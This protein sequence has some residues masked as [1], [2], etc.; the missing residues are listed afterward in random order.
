MGASCMRPLPRLP[1]TWL[2]G[3]GMGWMQHDDPT[4]PHFL[5]SC[6]TQPTP[7][8]PSLNQPNQHTHT[9][10]TFNPQI[11][12]HDQPIHYK[13]LTTGEP[14]GD[15]LLLRLPPADHLVLP[16]ADR[17]GLHHAV[18]QAPGRSPFTSLARKRA[19]RST[20]V[21]VADFHSAAPQSSTTPTPPT[22]KI[23]HA[24]NC[25]SARGAV[26]SS[27]CWKGTAG[28][29]PGGAGWGS[30]LPRYIHIAHVY[31]C[32]HAHEY[33]GRQAGR[34][35]CTSCVLCVMGG[36]RAWGSCSPR[37]MSR[38]LSLVSRSA[39]L[40]GAASSLPPTVHIHPSPH[41]FT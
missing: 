30:C 22:P 9:H 35:V 1:S 19:H 14:P 25:S 12:Q 29:G 38:T 15:A 36:L 37:C 5:D 32:M 6:T 3:G 18:L 34:H 20:V 7:L 17:A 10:K 40:A 31:V 28:A 21:D 39:C 8:L 23:T 41:I 33:T 4:V 11:N 24:N 13:H 2:V 26:T 16:A 27:S